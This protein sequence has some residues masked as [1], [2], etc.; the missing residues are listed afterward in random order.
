MSDSPTNPDMPSV[1]QLLHRSRANEAARSLGEPLPYPDSPTGTSDLL[2]ATLHGHLVP[3]AEVP[4][5]AAAGICGYCQYPLDN[6]ESHLHN[7]WLEGPAASFSAARWAAGVTEY[8]RDMDAAHVQLRADSEVA[9][10]EYVARSAEINAAYDRAVLAAGAAYDAAVLEARQ[11]SP[12]VRCG[13]C[14]RLAGMVTAPCPDCPDNPGRVD[15][16]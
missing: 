10:A 13:S 7:G 6:G 14:G 15:H 11:A 5:P 16:G 12:S 9:W 3:P 4:T 1:A 2:E 8:T